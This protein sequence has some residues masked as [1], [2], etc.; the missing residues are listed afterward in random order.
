M[1][2]AGHATTPKS[3]MLQLAADA[4]LRVPLFAVLQPGV[5]AAELVPVL[6]ALGEPLA[7]RSS[8]DAEDGLDTS[9]AG[10][11]HSELGV[12]HAGLS[13]AVQRVRASAD[14]SVTQ[15]EVLVMTQVAAQHAG[16]AVLEEPYLDDLIEVTEGLADGLVGGSV[17]GDQVLL[18]RRDRHLDADE[19][20]QRRL[21]DL[22]AGVRQVFGR[23]PGHVLGNPDPAVGWD[24]EPSAGWDVEWADDG[25][26]C[27]LL[28]VRPLLQPTI[29]NETL[30]LANHA[31]ILPDLP[32]DFMTSLIVEC[33]PRLLEWYGSLDPR[34]PV[35]RDLMVERAGRPLLNNSLLQDILRTWGLPTSLLADSMGGEADG[36]PLSPARLARSL[37][38]L[39]GVARRQITAVGD[40]AARGHALQRDARLAARS[41][42]SVDGPA[43]SAAVDAAAAAYAGLVTG[44]FA[45]A[46]AHAVQV[47]L[48]SRLGLL[49][50]VQR[51][52]PTPAGQLARDLAAGVSPTAL[53]ARHGHRGVYESDL[54]RP[55]F[56]EQPELLE[57]ARAA[58]MHRTGRSSDVGS[59]IA[60]TLALPLWWTARRSLTA[61]EQLRDEGMQ[62]FGTVRRM[63]LQAAAN[64]LENPEDVWLL[65][66]DEARSLDD[67]WR[68]DADF[69]AERRSRR[70]RRAAVYV[71]DPVG[72]T[73]PL[74]GPEDAEGPLAGRVLVAGS[75]SGTAWVCH[76]PPTD[77][78]PV[79]GPVILVA[80]AID[81]GWA[82]AFSQVDGVLLHLGGDLS[83]G[84][85]ILREMGVPTLTG[86]VDVQRRL[87]TGDHITLD[88]ESGVV[89]LDD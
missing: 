35:Q 64:V 73:A 58:A 88:G 60:G 1:R 32:S 86:I 26:T 82:T 7:V 52:A 23:R 70:E 45:L 36:E 65:T 81:G 51:R 53:V 8:F 68:P 74:I 72:R 66:T 24:V 9:A 25:E 27:W 76:E 4:G 75:V 69:L 3:R 67:G 20:W 15:T 83:H 43:M 13:G 10:R 39:L 29:R 78:P 57:R 22:L 14:E 61:R 6:S 80:R 59:T 46:N 71:P 33:G 63:V 18:P 41:A 34:L 55:R 89:T 12:S 44:M 37:P 42:T 79:E 21:A 17:E 30:T 19:A 16:V 40:A 49:D 77:V 2:A 62:A 47:S 50:E 85:L 56:A 54:A 38:A 84:A 5:D 48:L 28:Q 11:F 87:S 31:E